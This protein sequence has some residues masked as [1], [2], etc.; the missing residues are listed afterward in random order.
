MKKFYLFIIAALFLNIGF[1]Q[2]KPAYKLFNQKGKAVKYSKMLK[3]IQTA[4]IVFFGEQHTD[5]ISHWM[6]FEITKDL[7]EIKK[8]DLTIGAEM[9]EADQ[10]LVLDEYLDSAFAAEKF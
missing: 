3:E 2:D 4:D 9:F 8:K 6:Q 7:F 5:P 10:Q 1:A